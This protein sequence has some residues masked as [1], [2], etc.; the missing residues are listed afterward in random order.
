MAEPGWALG[1]HPVPPLLPF[2]LPEWRAQLTPICNA[3][4]HAASPVR[5]VESVWV[6]GVGAWP[7][8]R[9]GKECEVL[10]MGDTHK[11]TRL[12]GNHGCEPA[13]VPLASPSMS[14]CRGGGG[15]S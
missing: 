7:S 8:P 10:D 1:D 5:R 13:L 6:L 9:T 14:S 4:P 12:V 2:A 15:R 11:V 3:Y